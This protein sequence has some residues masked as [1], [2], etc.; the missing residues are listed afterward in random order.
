MKFTLF[1]REFRAK[2]PITSIQKNL[3]RWFEQ[4]LDA[5]SNSYETSEYEYSMTWNGLDI[6]QRS[7]NRIEKNKLLNYVH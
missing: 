4:R 1:L 7:I 5:Y 2:I 6:L 3:E